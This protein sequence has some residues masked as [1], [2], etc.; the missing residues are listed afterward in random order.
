MTRVDLLIM[1]IAVAALPLLYL[2]L[3]GPN[4]RGTEVNIIVADQ[5]P[6]RHSLLRDQT[7]A[8]KGKLGDSIITINNGKAAFI[9][10]PCRNK[11]CIHS[12]WHSRN[13]DTTAC[14]PNRIT[15]SVVGDGIARFDSVTF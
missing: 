6:Q 4:Y 11:Q 2:Q 15:L 5:K 10:S 12:G 1:I 7:L 9:E 8:I 13:G 14:L 3:W